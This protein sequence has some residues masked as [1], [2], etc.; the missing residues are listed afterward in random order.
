MVAGKEPSS[1]KVSGPFA[2]VDADGHKKLKIIKIN[3]K[4]LF[5]YCT[6]PRSGGQ[7][8]AY[9]VDSLGHHL[10]T[11]IMAHYDC[12]LDEE[13]WNKATPDES[14]CK[15]YIYDVEFEDKGRLM[16]FLYVLNDECPSV[17]DDCITHIQ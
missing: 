15:A 5:G 12:E 9:Q 7:K 10:E 2:D 6:H 4:F 3:N 11:R 8:S 17:L 16:P 14:N 13:N 1:A